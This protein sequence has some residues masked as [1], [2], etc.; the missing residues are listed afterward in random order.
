MSEIKRY[1]QNGQGEM[2]H[3]TDG[4]Y[5]TYKDHVSEVERLKKENNIMKLALGVIRDW[6]FDIMG[7]CVA[8]A[9]AKAAYAL[10][11]VAIKKEAGE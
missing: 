3:H 2:V 6:P 1:Y 11:M 8:E 5:V 9:K 7:D 10:Q 4:Y